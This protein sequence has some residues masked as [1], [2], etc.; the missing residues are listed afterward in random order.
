MKTVKEKDI[1][2]GELMQRNT[3]LGTLKQ[4]LN[5]LNQRFVHSLFFGIRGYYLLFFVRERK[6][7]INSRV[8]TKEYSVS[9]AYQ[10]PCQL[11]IRQFRQMD[12]AEKV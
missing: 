10:W 6:L 2:L 11:T 9:W 7:V 5:E 1:L 3:E 12:R 8:C 4:Q